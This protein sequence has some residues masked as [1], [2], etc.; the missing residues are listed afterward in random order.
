MVLSFLLNLAYLIGGSVFYL[1][2]LFGNID[3]IIGCL[4]S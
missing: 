4:L 1:L 3:E 2:I